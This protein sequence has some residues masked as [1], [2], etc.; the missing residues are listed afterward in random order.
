[1]KILLDNCIAYRVKGLLVGHDVSHAKDLGWEQL[2]NGRL[3]ATA[4]QADFEVMITVDKRIK[5]EQNLDR[6]PE[7][8][9][10][11]DIPDSRLPAIAAIVPRIFRHWNWLI[12][13]VSFRLT[14][15]D[16]S[17]VLPS[18]SDQAVAAHPPFWVID[19]RASNFFPVSN[20]VFSISSATLPT[21]SANHLRPSRPRP[22]D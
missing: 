9:I 20:F 6:L 14:R 5:Y 16:K 10:E 2:S 7:S 19:F 17:R 11:I 3:L 18:E 1:V 21:Q 22:P 8:V 12:N 13:S 4:Q 15:R